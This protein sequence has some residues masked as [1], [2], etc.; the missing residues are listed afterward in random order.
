MKQ[1]N[2][3]VLLLPIITL[4]ACSTNTG[5]R[6]AGIDEGIEKITVINGAVPVYRFTLPDGASFRDY[7]SIT[8]CFLVDGEQYGKTA[9]VRAYGNYPPELFSES[10]DFMFL[11]FGGGEADKNGP[12]LVS[13]V[14]GS[15]IEIDQVSGRAGP[16]AW[17]T[18]QFPLHGKRHQR[19]NPANFPGDNASGDFYFALGLGTAEAD[20]GL[21]YY[22][23]EIALTSQDGTRKIVSR[24]S[25]F[26]RP[27]FAG[28]AE[29]IPELRREQVSAVKEAASPVEKGGP[30]TI[31]VNT[32]TRY[33]MVTGFGGMSNAWNSPALTVDDIAAMYGEQG[34]GYNIFRI[35]LY[36]DPAQWG[37]LV[38]VARKA[39]SY[40]AIILASPWT[41]P[42]ELKSNNSNVGGYL[43]PEHYAQY[44]GHLAAFVR[45][46]ADNGVRIDAISFQNE[47]DIQVGYDS[48]DWTPEQMLEFVKGYGRSIGDVKIIPGESFQFRRNF[49]DPLLNDP[50]ALENFDIIGAHIY[51][52]G[53]AAYPLALEKGKDIWMTEHLFNTHG[54]Y[55]NDLTWKAA[56][57][58]AKEIH[59]CMQAGFN[60]YLWWYLKRFYSMIGD[61]EYGSPAG[62]ALRRGYVMSHYAQ[63]ATGRHRV[64]ALTRGNPNVLVSSY[65]SEADISL[66]IINTGSRPSKAR[67]KIPARARSLVAVESSEAG[68]MRERA[69]RLGFDKKSAAITLAPQSIVSLRF[70]K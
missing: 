48:C 68:T 19:Y 6:D 2:W 27:A 40:G 8:G 5:R 20:A 43:L 23:K 13:N 31:Q 4:A 16:N 33:Q 60:A 59:D 17:F 39:Q 28:Y 51:G 41:P 10:G 37:D 46:M 56:L 24:G 61:G 25:G 66:V 15:N 11:D 54:N 42:P 67:V 12:Y 34:L 49:T 70:E 50:A 45:F 69:V 32:G 35:I 63:Y 1:R 9:R 14:I 21:T 7:T 38:E 18:L 26:A 57:I 53:L 44:A 55:P 62:E 29:S 30:V 52:G 22:A 64:H 47:P 3:T 58:V 36:H 65:E